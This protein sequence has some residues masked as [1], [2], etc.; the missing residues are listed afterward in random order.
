VD[1]DEAAAAAAS[2]L[3]DSQTGESS[4]GKFYSPLASDDAYSSV[5]IPSTGRS[6]KRR[7]GSHVS[8]GVGSGD[9]DKPLSSVPYPLPASPTA[10][11]L[12][13]LHG[14]SSLSPGHHHHSLSNRISGST[15]ARSPQQTTRIPEL[16]PG[17]SQ[18]YHG[19]TYSTS[20]AAPA[21]ALHPQYYGQPSQQHHQYYGYGQ[22]SSSSGRG[23]YFPST[24]STVSSARGAAGGG[25]SMRGP[26]TIAPPSSGYPYGGPGPSN[27]SRAGMSMNQ[28]AHPSSSAYGQP[29]SHPYGYPNHPSYAHGQPRPHHR[30]SGS[31]PVSFSTMRG[32]PNANPSRVSGPLVPPL[33]VSDRRI[34]H[35]ALSSRAAAAAVNTPANVNTDGDD[36]LTRY[37]KAFAARPKVARTPITSTF[38]EPGEFGPYYY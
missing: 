32:H 13:P 22:S 36:S 15:S 14:A 10:P 33:P 31:G 6:T 24:S 16:G 23:G 11:H 1:G 17:P 29:P 4:L 27:M 35:H 37:S 28:G 21:S 12:P 19:D 26:A 18:L 9:E 34:P 25:A 2:T 3:P 30:S 20:H 5:P 8:V 7:S 38:A